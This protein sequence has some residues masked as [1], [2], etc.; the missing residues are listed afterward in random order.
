[1]LRLSTLTLL[2]V[3]AAA[4][5]SACYDHGVTGPVTVLSPP[6]NLVYQLEPSGDPSAPS[7]IL[8]RWDAVNDPELEAYRV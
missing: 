8:L 1:M 2:V 4:T 3:A 6:A 5:L 7:G